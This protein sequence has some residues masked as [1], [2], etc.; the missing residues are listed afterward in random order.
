M[1]WITKYLRSNIHNS[2]STHV[3]LILLEKLEKCTPVTAEFLACTPLLMASGTTITPSIPSVSWVKF[4]ESSRE[5]LH[6]FVFNKL[7][8]YYVIIP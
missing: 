3:I 5:L 8:Y 2:E 6:P 7:V 1:D 4:G